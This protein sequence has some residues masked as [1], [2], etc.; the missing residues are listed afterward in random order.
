MNPIFGERIVLRE[1]D[2]RDIE[3]AWR[4]IGDDRVTKWLSF[5]S[6]D[7]VA[8]ESM[9]RGAIERSSTNP[10]NEFY[11]VIARLKDDEL[12]GF[13]RLG[14]GGVKAGKL[15]YALRVEAWRHGYGLEAIHLMLQLGFGRLGLHR[16]TAAIG[17]DNLASISLVERIGFKYE[18]D[19]A[20]M[21]L[22]I[23]LGATV[24]CIHS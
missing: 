5:D 21:H 12:I 6:R 17:P 1:F 14:V 2:L 11:L 16:I 8:T 9:V 24:F 23:T 10:R 20:T 15:G 4:V 7:R 22:P 3:S 19:F 18:V 13:I